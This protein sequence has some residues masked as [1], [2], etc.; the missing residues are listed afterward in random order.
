MAT[1]YSPNPELD[2]RWLLSGIVL[3]AGALAL[4]GCTTPS[5]AVTQHSPQH[6]INRTSP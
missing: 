5:L 6:T 2:R 3:A 4:G 1:P